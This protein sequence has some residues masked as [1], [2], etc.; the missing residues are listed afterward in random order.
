M[1]LFYR[2]ADGFVGDIVPYYWQGLYHV[3]Y[4]KAPLPPLRHGADGT[5]YA[6]LVSGDLVHW[7]EWPLVIAPGAAGEPDAGGC[8]T[9]S[10]IERAGVIHLFYT[11]YAGDGQPQTI[12]HATSRDLRTW[13][14]DP[15]N[16]VLAADPRWYEP[17]DWRDPF[18][19]WNEAAGEYWMLLAGRVKDGPAN[20]RGCTALADLP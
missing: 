17:V 6:H 7:E 11:G 1:A 14:K 5:A 20:R 18:P 16:P 13:Q 8:W 2:P 9:G 19:F 3:F 4:L 15:R 12:C 10:V